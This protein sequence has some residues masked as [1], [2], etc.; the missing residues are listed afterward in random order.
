MPTFINVFKI[1]T[2]IYRC[3]TKILPVLCSYFNDVNNKYIIREK[4]I[5]KCY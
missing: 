3:T 5:L 1:L 2:S 4:K